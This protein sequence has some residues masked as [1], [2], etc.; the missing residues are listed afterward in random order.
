MRSP[1]S[2]NVVIRGRFST[3]DRMFSR[4]LRVSVSFSKSSL[5]STS[6]VSRYSD[7]IAHA[8]VC[9]ASISRR[10]SSSISLATSAE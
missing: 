8:S 3:S 4:S 6:R 9:A 1:N 10:T 5:A 7:R 2:L